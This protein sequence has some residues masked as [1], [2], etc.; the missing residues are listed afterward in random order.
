RALRVHGGPERAGDAPLDPLREVPDRR[1]PGQLL[2]GPRA[3]DLDWRIGHGPLARGAVRLSLAQRAERNRV[4][5]R[6]AES[7]G[8]A[9]R[10]GRALTRGQK[11]AIGFT[12][13]P[14]PPRTH[15]GATANRNSQ[16]SRSAHA[17]DRRERSR[18]SSRWTPIATR[19]HWCTGTDH[20]G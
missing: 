13:D 14:V 12:G 19:Q 2:H 5:P 4:L 15:S 10:P 8:R 18:L 3:A 1:G 16:R 7:R 11:T 17:A 20:W 9:R 6:A